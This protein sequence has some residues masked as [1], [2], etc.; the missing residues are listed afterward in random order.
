LFTAIF[1]WGQRKTIISKSTELM[2]RMDDE[3]H[4]FILDHSAKD[5]INLK[6]FKHRTF[7]QED[8]MYFIRF[9]HYHYTHSSSLES[10]FLINGTCRD[11]ET[12]LENFYNLFFNLDAVPQRTRKHISHPFS[13][14]TCKRL[15]MYLR[16]MVRS[17]QKGVDFGLWKKIKPLQLQ[18]PMDVHVHRVAQRLGLLSTPKR[19][20][21]AVTEL[22]RHLR[23]FDPEDP[24]KYDF[25]LFNLG[26]LKHPL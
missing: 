6:G 14:S 24:V 16:W 4:R 9:L 11:I 21:S 5:L 22:T 10:A 25:A 20:W 17:K 12:S 15:C 3:P 19:N 8:L 23:E 13:L 2:K 1:S 26:Q 18:I 7:Q